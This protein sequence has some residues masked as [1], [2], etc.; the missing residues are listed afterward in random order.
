MVVFSF[1][2]RRFADAGLVSSVLSSLRGVSAVWS[3]CASGADALSLAWARSVGVSVRRWPAAWSVLGRAAGP[4]RSRRL[5]RSLPAGSLAVCFVGPSLPFPGR[6]AVVA[7]GGLVAWLRSVGLPGSSASVALC[8]SAGVPVVCVFS[9][10]RRVRVGGGGGAAPTD[11]QSTK[12]KQ[13]KDP[14]GHVKMPFGKHKGTMI[15]NVPLSYILFLLRNF[16]DMNDNLRKTLQNHLAVRSGEDAPPHPHISTMNDVNARD[17]KEEDLGDDWRD[18]ARKQRMEDAERAED[19][20]FAP[21]LDVRYDVYHESETK[22]PQS[23]MDI[24]AECSEIVYIVDGPLC[25]TC[26]ERLATT[27]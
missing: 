21:S 22:G 20:G 4:A 10:G 5:V 19:E 24:C 13:L 2:G 1:G 11:K 14:D 17:S 25:P 8:R 7:A 23:E 27:A 6:A 16:D 18:I 26:A 9:C 15:M 12:S 3:G